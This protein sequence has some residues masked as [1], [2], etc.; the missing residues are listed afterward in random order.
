M[1]NWKMIIGCGSRD[2]E[3]APARIGFGAAAA[4]PVGW[5]GDVRCGI[6]L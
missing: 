3:R 4:K 6:L 2:E 5:P 1:K